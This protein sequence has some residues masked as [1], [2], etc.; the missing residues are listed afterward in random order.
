MSFLQELKRRNVYRVGIAYVVTAWLILQVADVILGNIEAPDGA[1]EFI[2]VLL[3]VGFVLTLFLAWVFE[4]TPDGVKR[5]SEVDRSESITRT[6]G[7]KLDRFI[8][9]ILAVA[10]AYFAVDKWFTGKLAASIERSIAVLPFENRSAVPE[11]VYFV[12]GIHDDILTQI[13]KLSGIDKV[14]SRTSTERYRE[15][16]KPMLQIGQELGVATILEGGVQRAGNRVRINVQLIDAATDEHIWAETYDREL[17]LGELFDVQTEIAREVATSLHAALTNVDE[18]RLASMPTD[19]LEAY[20]QFVLGRREL[21]ARTAD[22]LARAFDH[23]TRAVE[24]DPEYAMAY[25]G[26]TDALSL[27]IEYSVGDSQATTQIRQQHIDRALS[28]DPLLGEA[29]ASLGRLRHL[30]RDFRGAIQAYERAIELAPNYPS[31]YHWY[32]ILLRRIES[33]EE[34]AVEMMRKAVSLDP[35]APILAASLA[36]ALRFK[37]DF[38]EAKSVLMQGVREYPRFPSSYI[39]LRDVLIDQGRLGEAAVWLR[40]ANELNPSNLD[41]RSDSC[42]LFLDLDDTEAAASC[43]ESLRIDFQDS[44]ERTLALF[45]DLETRILIAR[46]EPQAAVDYAE[47]LAMSEADPRLYGPLIDAYMH[48]A[49][50]E[51]A[52]PMLEQF[53]PKFFAEGKIVVGPHEIESAIGV[54]LSMRE[55][56][57]W[58]P[59]AEYLAGQALQTM[60]RMRRT[61]GYGFQSFDVPAHGIR[62]D[63][64]LAVHALR[65]AIDSGWRSS[66]WQFRTPSYDVVSLDEDLRT[67]WN[68]LIDELE[69]DIARQREWFYANKDTPLFELAS[70]D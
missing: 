22:S 18:E 36:D 1:F 51:K 9:G 35:A 16:D 50:W 10:V 29:Y 27:Q 61:G 6:T 20:E 60:Q 70:L 43:L 41:T 23:F 42:Y 62:G 13:A 32:S 40:H 11:D 47:T 8:I 28:L 66:S 30:G 58:P 54:A 48:N 68:A 31:A 14:I 5:E 69:T 12:D 2:L 17:T 15:T 37:G 3:A 25:V 55:G 49:Q 67:E 7:R 64:D 21:A 19:N 59:R 26:L 39:V 56:D 45:A 24:L 44:P 38:E 33:R 34:E 57:G 46:G 63:I 4:I 65:E 53:A 52:R